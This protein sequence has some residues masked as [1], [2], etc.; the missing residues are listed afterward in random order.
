MSK[1]ANF[2]TPGILEVGIDEA[3]RG[4]AFG[5]VYAAAVIWPEDIQSNQVKDSKKFSKTADRERAYDFVIE[6]ALAYGI[7]YA[8]PEEIDEIG[9][10][11]AVMASMHRAVRN[12]YINPDHILVDGNYFR[13]FC[14]QND[15]F[16]N[17]STVIK[18]D[19]KYYSIAAASIIAKVEHDRYIEDL[20]K[21]HPVLDRYDLKSNKGYGTAKHI[22]AM[23]TYGITQF[24]RQSFKCC[25]GVPL[26]MI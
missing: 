9:I 1:L 19:D 22:E 14:D 8:E 12:T 10:G 21:R 4:P 13:P 6:N 23:K 7:G 15:N 24:H 2:H 20:C 25:Q 16:T 26:Q 5:R 17:Y 18:G 11:K 3:G